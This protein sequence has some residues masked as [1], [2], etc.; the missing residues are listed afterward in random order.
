MARER[1][2]WLSCSSVLTDVNIGDSGFDLA[3]GV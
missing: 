3:E 2:K 1:N